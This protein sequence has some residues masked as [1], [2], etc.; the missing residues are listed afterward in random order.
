M[1]KSQL[2]QLIKEEIRKVLNENNLLNENLPSN[3]LRKIVL[4][5]VNPKFH[6]SIENTYERYINFLQAYTKPVTG[7]NRKDVY[8]TIIKKLVKSKS[9]DPTEILTK[10]MKPDLD[11][12]GDVMFKNSSAALSILK[13][14]DS[15]NLNETQEPYKS[16]EPYTFRKSSG[17][18][19]E[20][21]QI[22]NLIKKTYPEYTNNNIGRIMDADMELASL[23]YKVYGINVSVDDI[24][25]IIN[26]EDP[27]ELSRELII[28]KNKIEDLTGEPMLALR[29]AMKELNII[30]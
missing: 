11:M 20:V 15:S 16:Y 1:K 24:Y 21:E 9:I 17:Y 13:A 30:P 26:T 4:K 7:P 22:K 18:K 6:D 23:A 12:L 8:P 28:A 25:D 3:E 14:L 27:S 2:K 29:Q 5:Y 19:E 10:Y